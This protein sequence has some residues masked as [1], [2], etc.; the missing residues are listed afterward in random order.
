MRMTL[1][2]VA[3]DGEPVLR[4]CA[5]FTRMLTYPG[6]NLWMSPGRCREPE[7]LAHFASAL[8]LLPSY[9]SPTSP[10][11]VSASIDSTEIIA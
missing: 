4:D 8:K 3:D 6:F 7:E 2:A 11:S 10:Q 1:S 9:L 5:Q